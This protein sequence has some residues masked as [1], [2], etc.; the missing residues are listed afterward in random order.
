MSLAAMPSKRLS[1]TFFEG[2]QWISVIGAVFLKENGA[3]QILPARRIG[4]HVPSIS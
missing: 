1:N 3:S 4:V 2:V